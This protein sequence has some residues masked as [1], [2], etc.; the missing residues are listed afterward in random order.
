MNR[1][2]KQKERKKKL[3]D[4]I[5]NGKKNSIVE[6]YFRNYLKNRDRFISVVSN[7][8]RATWINRYQIVV[9]IK[10][11]AKVSSNYTAE[12]FNAAALGRK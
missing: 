9:R 12:S 4:T 5:S 3:A 8:L 2:R 10:I 7:E 11:T 6:Y 1:E